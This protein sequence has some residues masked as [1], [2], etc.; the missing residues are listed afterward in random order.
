MKHKNRA[1][2][3]ILKKETLE[4]LESLQTAR[5]QSEILREACSLRDILPLPYV[6]TEK[7]QKIAEEITEGF[8]CRK[9]GM[10]EI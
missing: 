3:F 6:L 4:L 8:F 9:G 2:V 10:N 7:G 5:N 1:P